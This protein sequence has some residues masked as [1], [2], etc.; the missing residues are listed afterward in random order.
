[1]PPR[2]PDLALAAVAALITTVLAFPFAW[3]AVRYSGFLAR[4]VEGTNFV[5][6][7]MPGIVTALAL[8]TVA[9]RAL[10]RCTRR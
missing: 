9:I 4:V 8:V 7:S 2:W 3:V 1:M 10:P 6:S 5:T